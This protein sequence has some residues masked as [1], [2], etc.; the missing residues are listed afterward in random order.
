MFDMFQGFWRA[1][2]EPNDGAPRQKRR[3]SSPAGDSSSASTSGWESYTGD[4]GEVE[5]PT[6]PFIADAIIANPPCFAH[7]HCAEKLGV[8]LHLMFTFPYSPTATMPHPLANIQNS[9]VGREYTNAISYPMIEMMTWQGL[10]DLVNRFR[11]KT[12]GLEPVATLWAPGMISRLK[13]PFSYMWSPALIPK[14]HDWGDHIDIT[15]FV[16]LDL[17]TGFTPPDALA[18]F[19]AAGDK[20]VYIGFGS[21]VVDDPDALTTIIFDA[22]KLAGVRALVSKGWGG[23]GGED[24]ADIPDSVFMLDNTPHDWLFS[25]VAGVVHHGGAGTTAIGLYCGCPTMIVPFFGDQAFWGATVASAGAGAEP[26]P[27]KELTAQKLADGIKTL[28]GE[29]CQSAAKDISRRIKE[30]DGDGAEN[31]VRSFYRGLD[32]LKR[33]KRGLGSRGKELGEGGPGGPAEGKWG[34]A[35]PG[36]RCDMLEDKVAVWRIRR[37]KVKLS[38]LAAWA[39]VRDGRIGWRDLRLCVHPPPLPITRNHSSTNA[40]Q[41]VRHTEWND[42]D[43]PGEPVSGGFSAL[44][45]SVAGVAKGVVSL[46]YSWYKGARR[47]DTEEGLDLAGELR[48][49]SRT[50]SKSKGRKSNDSSTPDR[51]PDTGARKPSTIPED[52]SSDTQQTIHKELA[53]NTAKGLLKVARAGARAPVEVSLAVAQGFHNAPRLYGDTVRAPYRITGM[54]SGLRAA[55]KELALGVYDGVTGVVVKP[56]QGAKEDGPVG[57]VKGVGKGVA[58]GLLKTNAATAGLVGFTLKGMHKEVR[59][60]RDRKV[61][62]KLRAARVMQGAM[63]SNDWSAEKGERGDEALREAVLEG[64]RKVEAQ[65]EERKRMDWKLEERISG[66]KRG[67]GRRG[68]RKVVWRRKVNEVGAK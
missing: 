67:C 50:R 1:C 16:F 18:Q 15:G 63:E 11:E 42:F 19:L 48:S 56:Y 51:V 13:V 59:K 45:G 5:E 38:A 60:K 20:P 61:M 24:G 44:F 62:E 66:V 27:H 55:G 49:R 58:G 10:G 65:K 26:V 8:P 6:R 21:I 14:P 25:Q 4:E 39:L 17:A 9:N 22:I 52:D 23:I 12:L 43:G 68:V 30:D 53:H 64:W 46:P 32:N 3:N 33:G 34:S 36:I 47:F 7:V 37:T 54:H 35:G 28:L 29:E 41:S 57:F 31:A 40:K 2:V